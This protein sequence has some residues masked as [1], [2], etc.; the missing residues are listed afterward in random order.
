MLCQAKSVI[1]FKYDG[2]NKLGVFTQ[3]AGSPPQYTE[4]G[5]I[6]SARITKGRARPGTKNGLVTNKRTLN[7]RLVGAG[8]K[9]STR[10]S[11]TV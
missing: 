3:M 1:P 4:R 7:L 8:N 2:L 5:R 9:Q 10:L 6:P 11:A